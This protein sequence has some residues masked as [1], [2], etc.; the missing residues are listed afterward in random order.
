MKTRIGKKILSVALV[1]CIMIATFATPAFAA[2]YDCEY[3]PYCCV[4]E[5]IAPRGP[6]SPVDDE[7]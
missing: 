4:V 2:T 5:P 6:G 1:L 7:D 3:P